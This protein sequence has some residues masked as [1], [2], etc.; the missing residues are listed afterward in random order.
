MIVRVA[1][2][3]VVSEAFVVTKGVNQGCELDLAL[4]SLMFSAI[5]RDGCLEKRSGISI[6]YRTDGHLSNSRRMQ[7][8]TRASK[9]TVQDLLFTD[10]CAINT[11]IEEKIQKRMNLFATINTQYDNKSI[12]TTKTEVSANCHPA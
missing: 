3:R 2:N 12:N 10:D 11:V 6:A 1:D 5:W 8:P 7:I 4:F 9:T